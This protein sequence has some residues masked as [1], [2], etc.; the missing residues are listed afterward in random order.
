[1]K[2]ILTAWLILQATIG[3]GVEIHV[4]TDSSSYYAGQDFN[5]NIMATNPLSVS[6]V[7]DF[8]S[9]PQ[10]VIAADGPCVDPSWS[11]PVFT[12]VTIPPFGTHVWIEE[13][14]W[15]KWPLTAGSHYVSG[16]VLGYGDAISAP[17]AVE[18]AV[19]PQDK[20]LID[21]HT[22]PGTDA[23]TTHLFAYDACGVH[24]TMKTS[25]VGMKPTLD[26]VKQRLEANSCTYPPGFNITAA[27]DFPV[28]GASADAYTAVGVQI[29][30]LAKNGDG[31][32][33]ASVTS[34]PSTHIESPLP[35]RLCTSERIETLEWWPSLSNASVSVD[36]VCLERLPSLFMECTQQMATLR[37]APDVVHCGLEVCTNLQDAAWEPLLSSIGTNEVSI[38]IT[39]SPS[40]FYRLK[41]E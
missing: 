11:L 1:M 26:P 17:F 16:R 29:T 10:V 7:L 2:Y 31:D 25:G 4:A 27:L 23:H 21:F 12:S 9:L 15:G 28:Y 13:F 35:I 33:I 37:W 18:S 22:I 30:M 8:P 41:I 20:V 32:V 19:L 24:F 40:C 3:F 6:T 38:P 14:D 34:A 39:N 36:N 5:V